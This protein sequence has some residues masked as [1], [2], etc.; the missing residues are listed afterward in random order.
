MTD[1]RSIGDRIQA[2]RLT[3]DSKIIP[4]TISSVEIERGIPHYGVEW[5]DGEYA[6][7]IWLESD[8]EDLESDTSKKS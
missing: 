1:S 8:L 6:D 3:G 2:R 7:E 4:G 5:D